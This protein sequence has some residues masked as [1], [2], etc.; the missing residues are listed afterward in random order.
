M[1]KFSAG[2]RFPMLRAAAGVPPMRAWPVV[3][4]RWL[5]MIGVPL[6]LAVVTLPRP[7]SGAYQDV[8]HGV[9]PVAGGYLLGYLLQLP[10]SGLLFVAALNL[11]WGLT[12]FWAW[13]SRIALWAWV[14]AWT[15]DDAVI[16]LSVGT[17]LRHQTPDMNI[18]T[19]AAIVQRLWYDPIVG[20][21]G[22][23]IGWASAYAWG[24]AML[25]TVV[26]LYLANRKRAWWQLLTPSLLLLAS[27][28]QT[29]DFPPYATIAMACF[30]AASLWFELFRF[31]PAAQVS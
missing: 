17:I 16:G 26:A 1:A 22:S 18:H 8:Y 24:L 13:L 9:G 28:V 23:V 12:G 2:E 25:S 20:G 11:T 27:F 30:A 15:A 7:T 19:V 5:L 21:I 6:A 4:L 31:G 3:V 29:S 14:L 10:L